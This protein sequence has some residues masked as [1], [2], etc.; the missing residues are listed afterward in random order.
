[1]VSTD[2]SLF[3]KEAPRFSAD[4][5][6][7]LSSERL[8][9]FPRHLV[10]ALEINWI[11]APSNKNICSVV[12][13]DTGTLTKTETDTE[14]ETETDTDTEMDTPTDTEIDTDMDTNMELEYFSFPSGAIV[15]IAPYG[16]P[17]THHGASSNSAMNS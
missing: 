13:T 3:K 5:V 17:V 8:F 10:R 9:K 4:F 2:R 7:P 1:M 15:A 11:I 16:L 12:L 6:H 14:T